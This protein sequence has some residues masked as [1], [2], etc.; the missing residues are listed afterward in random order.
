MHADVNAA[1]NIL[2]IFYAVQWSRRAQ[3]VYTLQNKAGM[4][5]RG[6]IHLGACTPPPSV[7]DLMA[8]TGCHKDG[9]FSLTDNGHLDGAPLNGARTVPCGR[10][11]VP[12]S[13]ERV[14]MST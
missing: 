7:N 14:V 9:L 4:V 1:F 8:G 11:L 12:T 5:L 10:N 3:S 2:F 6:R 13:L